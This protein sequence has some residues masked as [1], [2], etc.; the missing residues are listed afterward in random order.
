MT[1]RLAVSPCSH[2]ELSLDQALSTYATLGLRRFEAF[3][4]WVN[5]ALD[6]TADPGEYRHRAGQRGV[7]FCSL[8][9][10]AVRAEAFDASLADAVS[11]AEFASQLGV[12]VV[13]FKADSQETYK[14]AAGRFVDHIADVPVIP[15]LQN[16]AGSPLSRLSD[17]VHVVEAIDD[18]RMKVLLEIGHYH[19]VG[20]DWRQALSRFA[21]RIAL[22]HV[23]D[24]SGGRCVPFGQGDI[25]LHEVVSALKGIGYRGDIVLEAEVGD[26]ELATQTLGQAVDAIS[27]EQGVRV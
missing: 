20:D 21:D 4:S 17:M 14:Q 12:S 2:P 11:A 22:V 10:P 9:L 16:H 23:K 5:S 8:H 26:A 24:M 25:D 19:A 1:I 15:V 27:H 3:T 18:A 7:E 6:W 13:L